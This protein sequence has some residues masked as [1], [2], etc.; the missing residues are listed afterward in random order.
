MDDMKKLVY[1][2]L[3]LCSAG[4]LA[5]ACNSMDESV[6]VTELEESLDLKS[7]NGIMLARNAVDLK[8]FVAKGFGVSC[9]EFE[10]T[11]IDYK[12]AV[13][14][15]VAEATCLFLDGRIRL[16]VLTDWSVT[17]DGK[18]APSTTVRV[19]SSEETGP[20]YYVTDEGKVYYC[21]PN[22]GSSCQE[23]QMYFT[24]AYGKVTHFD[25]DCYGNGG[26]GGM[27]HKEPSY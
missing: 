21:V 19:K 23:C 3:V 7:P 1:S 16:A 13:V 14:G 5:W 15:C 2:L 20:N 24:K 25:C 10:I 27:C 8:E 22:E 9:D 4:L 26:K 18:V 17:S 6:A 11:N 12:D